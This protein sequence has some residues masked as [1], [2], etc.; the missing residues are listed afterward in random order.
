VSFPN[1]SDKYDAPAYLTPETNLERSDVS[2]IDVPEAVILC[3]QSDFFEYVTREHTEGEID[4]FDGFGRLHSLADT[5]GQVGVLGGF[6][7]GAPATAIHV[8]RLIARGAEAFCV[9]GG[10]AGL[11][12]NV[13]CYESVVCDRAVRDEGV[14]HHYLPSETYVRADEALTSELKSALDAAG[15]E[16][17]VGASWTT[18]AFFR[19]TVPEIEYYR[20]EGVLAVEMEAAAVFAVAEYRNV[21]AAALLCPFDLVLA[22]GWESKREP[23]V[24]GLRDLLVPARESL[25]AHVEPESESN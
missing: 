4:V 11:G 14:S 9:V 25:V 16:P 21:D 17:R 2:G 3:Y 12:G 24:A 20:E 15:F 8:E 23:T 13:A 10:C 19:E 1:Y 6:G 22:N 18:D 5:G 7:I